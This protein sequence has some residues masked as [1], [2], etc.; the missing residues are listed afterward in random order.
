MTSVDFFGPATPEL[1]AAVQGLPVTSYGTAF[2]A[3]DR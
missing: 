3:L 2:A 1:L